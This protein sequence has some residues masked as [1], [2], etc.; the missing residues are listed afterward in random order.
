[1]QPSCPVPDALTKLS[2][3]PDRIK[4]A[5]ERTRAGV[6]TFSWKDII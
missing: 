4:K 3:A 5:L 1:M 6:K 2:Y